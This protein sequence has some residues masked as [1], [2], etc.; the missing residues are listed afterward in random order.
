MLNA[1]SARQKIYVIGDIHGRADLLDE[2]IDKICLDCEPGGQKNDYLTITLGDYIDRGP[3]SREVLDRLSRDPFPTEF[4]PL[5]GNHEMLLEMFLNN[6]SAAFHWGHLGGL[7]T[8]RSYGIA[9]DC[10]FDR[11]ELEKLSGLLWNALPQRHLHFIRSLKTS[12]V[13]GNYFFCHAGIRPGVALEKQC[14]D[15]LLWIREEFLNSAEDFGKIIVH[16]HTPR[17]QP[18]I[19]QNRINID[20]GAFFSGCLTCLI[21][22][23]G[24]HRFL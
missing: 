1:Y 15:D 3:N 22:E 17:E 6:P 8:L 21:L 20:T 7:E 18:E 12:V 5:K 4:I 14:D 2:V 9:T 24:A 11:R 23:G 10:D 13:I 19:L 16:G